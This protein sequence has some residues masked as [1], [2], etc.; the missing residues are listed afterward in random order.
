MAGERSSGQGGIRTPEGIKP[1][2]LQPHPFDRFGTYPYTQIP[3]SLAFLKCFLL[4]K[5][6]S[7]A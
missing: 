5:L 4:P 6:I 2:G 1:C 3:N 7:S